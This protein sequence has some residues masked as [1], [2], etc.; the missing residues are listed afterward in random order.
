MLIDTGP[1]VALLDRNDSQHSACGRILQRLAASSLLTTWPC[2]TE[3]FYLL[4]RVGG[5]SSQEKLWT[6]RR[7]RRLLLLDATV[8]EVDRMEALMAQYQSVPMD[9]G[10]ASLV[11]TAESR[12]YR[13]LFTIDD[14]FYIYR[15]ADGSVLEI[16]Q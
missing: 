1:L 9:L 16:V 7:I 3:A 10:D 14:D 5:Y 11:A 2:F 15:L 6:M 8:A 12:G 4:S 13:N